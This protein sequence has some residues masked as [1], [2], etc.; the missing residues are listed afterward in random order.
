M[1]LNWLRRRQ[2]R[3]TITAA[4]APVYLDL[5]KIICPECGAWGMWPVPEG[6]RIAISDKI[7]V[8]CENGHNW[9]IS[10]AYERI[11]VESKP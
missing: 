1:I 7:L 10:G 9:G 11:S 6:F 8:I 2:K 5:I 3:V 4:F